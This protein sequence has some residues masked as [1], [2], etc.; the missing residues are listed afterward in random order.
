MVIVGRDKNDLEKFGE[1]GT[2]YIGRHIV[3]MGEDAHL[4]TKVFMDLLRPHAMLISGKRGT[5]KCVEE[6]TLVTLDDGSVVPIKNLNSNDQHIY[7]LN[8]KLKIS[9]MKKSKFFERTV[10]ALLHL[11]FRS[12]KEIKLTPEHPLLTIK[13]WI[14]AKYLGI[15]SRVATP[16]KIKVFGNKLMKDYKIKLLA[17]LIAEGHLGNNFVLFSNTD[18]DIVDEFKQAVKKFDRYLKINEHSH[19]GCYRISQRKRSIESVKIVRDKRGCFSKGTAVRPSKNPLIS[20]LRKIGLYGKLSSDKFI[21]Q[22]I[23][24]LPDYQLALFL[25]RLFSC[26]GSIYKTKYGNKHHWEISY[27]TSSKILAQQV[28]HLLL[29]FEVLSKMRSKKVRCNEKIF[30]TFE[31]V[32]VGGNIIRFINKIGFFGKKERKQGE[33]LEDVTKVIRNPNVDT[34]PK[35]IWDMYRPKNWAEVGRG[36]DYSIPK[37]LRSSINY[38]PSRQKVM[39]IAEIDGNIKMY[40][41][42]TSDIFWDEIVE[43][44]ELRGKF[45]VCDISVPIYHNFVANDIIVH[46]SYIAGVIAEEIFSLPEKFRQ[47]LATVMIDTMGIFWS[48]K[49][50]NEQQ[51]GLLREWGLGPKGFENTR[52][53]VPFKQLEEFERAGIPVDGGISI[54]PYEFSADEWR[55]AF[56]LS[57]TEPVG[58]ALEKNVNKLLEG[59]KKFTIDDLIRKIR[60][61]SETGEEIKDAL[62][63]MLTVANQWGVFGTEGID[64]DKIVQ[65]G[66][67]SIIDVSRLRAT[68]AWS[69]RNFLVAILSRKIYNARVIARKQEELASMAGKE[70]KKVFPMVWL[71]IDEAHNFCGTEQTVSSDPILTI[72]KQGREP[73]ISLVVITQMPNKIHQDVLSQCD[74]V[75]SHRLTS[76]ADLQSLHSIAQTYMEEEIWK[77]IN[78][79]PRTWKGSAIIIDDNLEK[80]FTVQIRPRVSHHAGGTAALI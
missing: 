48:M 29:R 78:R 2:G 37:G 3:G 76:R 60:E 75:I 23:F 19:K 11:K 79:L 38:G 54:A 62:D 67:N 52:V 49:M 13:G 16:R 4:T 63:N 22:N 58:I 18:G 50:P 27:S 57:A 47:D 43:V 35:E 42:A 74:L 20:W 9:P 17:Y 40:V 59:E 14:P 30:D 34:I 55:L 36:M 51:T 7:G 32:I 64:I 61:D 46:N 25:N 65:P 41:L 68:A 45:K 10:N 26:D 80:V 70:V 44:N 12:G 15:G 8:G 6:N 66:I 39:Q 72:A 21:S 53:Y 28:Q 5:G 73:G 71:I 33:A 31:L 56:N 69:V 77:Y 1:A 24:N